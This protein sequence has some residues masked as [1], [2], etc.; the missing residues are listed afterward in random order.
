MNRFWSEGGGGKSKVE[1]AYKS[2]LSATKSDCVSIFGNST[3]GPKNI[4][5]LSQ[6][7]IYRNRIEY[8]WKCEKK[9][10]FPPSRKTEH[11]I[12]HR[13]TTSIRSR[14]FRTKTMLISE[15]IRCWSHSN[16][17]KVF[18]LSNSDRICSWKLAS[19]S[20][21]IILVWKQFWN[22]NHCFCEH[23]FDKRQEERDCFQ[24]KRLLLLILPFQRLDDK[25]EKKN[26]IK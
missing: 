16:Q 26:S 20:K 17:I 22:E 8:R 13:D 10:K 5:N 14:K 2:E 9:K 23:S 18:T 15:S 25:I 21:R 3:L 24:T 4:R 7:R 11:R 1:A 19:N 12:L 6:W